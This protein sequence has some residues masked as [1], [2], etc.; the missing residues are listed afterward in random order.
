MS[1]LCKLSACNYHAS[2]IDYLILIACR[3]SP[4]IFTMRL[5]GALHQAAVLIESPHLRSDRFP[6]VTLKFDL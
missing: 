4:L 5:M 3:Y 6:A 1:E 2:Y